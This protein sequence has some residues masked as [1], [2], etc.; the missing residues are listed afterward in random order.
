VREVPIHFSD[1]LHGESKLSLREQLNYIRHLGRLAEYKLRNLPRIF[2]FGFVGGTGFFVDLGVFTAG[3]MLLPVPLAR[4]VAI[5]VAMTWNFYWN[6]R[7]TF[8]ESRDGSVLRQYLLF[9]GACLLGAVVSWG[10]S[11]ALWKYLTFF[12]QYPVVAAAIGIVAGVVFNFVASCRLV[13]RTTSDE[14]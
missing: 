2:K 6:R 7:W 12:A 9:C 3:L 10:T 1:R 5:W 14:D 13:F 8:F 4:A 11:V